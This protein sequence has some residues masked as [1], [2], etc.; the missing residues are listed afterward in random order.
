MGN[1]DDFF[2]QVTGQIS[3][4]VGS[5]DAAVV[6]TETDFASGTPNIFSLQLNTNMFNT[7][8]SR[9][10]V[11]AP[12]TCNTAATPSQ[13]LGW[14]QFIY[15]NSGV[16]FMQYWLIQYN[17]T[18]PAV[19]SDDPNKWYSY[20][21]PGPM[22]ISCFKNGPAVMVPVQTIAGLED[23]VPTGTAAGGGNDT[24]KLTGLSP[25]S[26]YAA[27]GDDNVLDLAQGWQAAEFNIF[28]D[29]CLN[30]AK[31]G[32]GSTIAVRTN[33]SDG[34]TN[35]PSCAAG[36]FTGEKNSLTLVTTP[37]SCC[38]FG[39]AT[40]SI[41]FVESNNAGAVAICPIAIQ[42][43]ICARGKFYCPQLNQCV[44]V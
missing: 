7:T 24:I 36:G 8:D 44:E 37:N 31:F 39:G 40:P 32:P 21:Y 33:V 4:A 20:P 1:G 19:A 2:T 22:D 18:C 28:G 29:C 25:P 13:C 42:P 12:S 23:M 16:A 30:T 9:G 34:T 41:E 43:P 11:V 10:N 14:Q 35:A 3:V 27:T 26:V 5:F 15:S 6:T 38:P 17:K